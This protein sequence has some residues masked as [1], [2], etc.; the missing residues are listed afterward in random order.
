MNQN[1]EHD[2]EEIAQRHRSVLLN[3]VLE[4][5]VRGEGG[6]YLD[7]TLGLGG[8]S[9]H[10][11]EKAGAL[12]GS[13]AELLGLDQDAEAIALARQRLARFGHA[14]HFAQCRFTDFEAELDALGWDFIDGALVDL[15][16]SSLQLDT[17][18]RG[19]S[20]IHDGPLDMRMDAHSG[21][22][23]AAYL[24]NYWSVEEL[25]AI[26]EE[27]GEEPLAGRIARAI[28]EA[29]VQGPIESTLQLAGIVEQAYPAKWRAT[30]RNHPATRTFQALRLAVNSE[31]EQIRTF[32]ELI[33]PRLRPG[34]RVA[35]ISFHSLEDRI[36]KHFFKTASTACLCPP[37]QMKCTCGHHAALELVSKKA[38]MASEAEER[39]NPRSRSAK[40]RVAQRTKA[41]F[42]LPPEGLEGV[43][44]SK[45]KKT[46]A[47]DK[48]K[49]RKG[50][51]KGR[52]RSFIAVIKGLIAFA[53]PISPF[54]AEV[55]A[56]PM[57]RNNDMAQRVFWGMDS[58]QERDA[59][60]SVHAFVG[61]RKGKA[62]CS[63]TGSRRLCRA[64]GF[65]PVKVVN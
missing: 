60:T 9:L 4:N 32:L 13:G 44:Y 8:H 48:V 1:I 54:A 27:L 57:G 22:E 18:E 42:S 14:A 19:F 31:L 39:A 33:V 2:I 55:D 46:A 34:G 17:P 37:R 6:R 38:I 51:W 47:H 65:I 41:P 59:H 53:K 63:V 52:V 5:L 26:I 30:A 35:V 21:R 43:P 50:G 23:S 49:G 28:V 3:E 56:A 29:R 58:L 45:T 10:I 12:H 16:V 40:L 15:G 24:A 61:Y 62:S 11:L 20:F 64:L 25:K 36:V 7:G